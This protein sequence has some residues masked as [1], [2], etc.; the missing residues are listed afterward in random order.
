MITNAVDA[1]SP[2]WQITS[3][4]RNRRRLMLCEFHSRNFAGMPANSGCCRRASTHVRSCFSTE[5]PPTSSRNTSAPVGHEIMHSPQDTQLEEPI[6]SSR[7]K[8][9]CVAYPLPDRPMT[10]FSFTS[11]QARTQRSQR[12]HWSWST[13]IRKELS[14]LPRASDRGVNDCAPV[15]GH[16][17]SMAAGSAAGSAANS[18][19]RA[20]QASSSRVSVS[21]P[22]SLA[23]R[24]AFQS[25]GR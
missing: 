22:S 14:S 12:M 11:L 10:W 7:S 9:I 19:A 2:S 15:S 23:G 20:P 6:G 4:A 5:V 21:R 3:P 25:A 17:A 24:L 18:S 1:Y 8:P 16:F 13:A